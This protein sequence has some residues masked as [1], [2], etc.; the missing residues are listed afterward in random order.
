MSNIIFTEFQRQQLESNPNVMK[1]SDRS[2]T[3]SQDFKLAAVKENL[4]GK[5]PYQIFTEK[6]FDMDVI[7]SKKPKQCLKRW[8]GTYDKYGEDGFYKERR[9]KGSTGRPSTNHLSAEDKLKKAEARIAYLEA[10]LDFVKK[11]D[12][13]ERQAKKKR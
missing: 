10:E 11:L 1:V 9:G 3:Y 4:A 8:R 7:G 5:G 12:E 13:V 2:I 6:G